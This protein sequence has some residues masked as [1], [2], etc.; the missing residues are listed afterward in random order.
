MLIEKYRYEI[1]T[2]VSS[3]S[4]EDVKFETVLTLH[5]DLHVLGTLTPS[6]REDL[7]Q[8]RFLP[9][10]AANMEVIPFTQFIL[11]TFSTGGL[12]V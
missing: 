5:R 9:T 8:I 12:N 6:T 11:M 4:R 2:I 3:L 10:P 7:D 1:S